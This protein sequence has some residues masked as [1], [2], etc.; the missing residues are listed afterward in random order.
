M[1][2][3]NIFVMSQPVWS[4]MNLGMDNHMNYMSRKI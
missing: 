2:M 1:H 4:L 3:F